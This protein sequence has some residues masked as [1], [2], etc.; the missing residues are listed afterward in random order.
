M[1]IYFDY[2][3]FGFRFLFSCMKVVI[4]VHLFFKRIHDL[5]NACGLYYDLID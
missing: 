3:S 5:L 4:N 1:F 2:F